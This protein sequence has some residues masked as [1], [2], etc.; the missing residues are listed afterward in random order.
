MG[1]VMKNSIF[2]DLDKIIE[3][4]VSSSTQAEE[5]AQTQQAQRVKSAGLVASKSKKNDDVDEAEEENQPEKDPPDDKTG[6]EKIKKIT[7]KPDD[8]A[9]SGAGSSKPGTRTSKKLSDPPEKVLKNPQYPDIQQKINTL[10]GASSLSKKPISSS[11]QQY[12]KTLSVPEKA[13]L[14]TYLTNLSQLMAPVRKPDE[15]KEP[16]DVGLVTK[17]R[18]SEKKSKDKPAEDKKEKPKSSGIVV[19]GED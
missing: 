4:A 19:V 9:D 16:S 17:F 8:A 6:E 7:G 14:L 18:S 11:V 5:I 1:K 3:A 12:L 15:V 2:S 13:A 10:R